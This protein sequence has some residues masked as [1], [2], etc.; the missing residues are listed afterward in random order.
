MTLSSYRK[1][2]PALCCIAA[3]VAG[4]LLFSLPSVAAPD[5]SAY[6]SPPNVLEGHQLVE[7]L[8]TGGYVI[9]FRHG[10]TD[11]SIDD[12]DWE[13]LANCKTQR[14]LSDQGRKQMRG[15]GEAIKALGIRVSTVLSSP[16]CRCIDTAKLAFGRAEII[17]DLRQGFVDDKAATERRARALRKMLATAPSEPGTN[18]VLSGHS[19]NLQAVTGIWL[20]EEGAAIVFKPVPVGTFTYIATIPPTRWQELVR[21]EKK[22]FGW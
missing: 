18:T 13:N 11:H 2:S 12:K 7:A 14:P 15:I 17:D 5:V 4:L 10:I 8:R 21:R 19:G 16:F 6:D 20:R 3:L 22:I 9:Y 1:S